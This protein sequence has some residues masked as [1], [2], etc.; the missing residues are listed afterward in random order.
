MTTTFEFAVQMD[1]GVA[2]L[3]TDEIDQFLDGF[4][5]EIIGTETNTRLRKELQGQPKIAGYVGPC[6]GGLTAL[7][8]P[9][10][11]YEDHQAHLQLCR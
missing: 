10:I 6:W 11:R 3:H 9:I 8:D 2:T 7:G 4:C 1:D 5:A